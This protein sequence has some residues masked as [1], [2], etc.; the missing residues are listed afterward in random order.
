MG[1]VDLQMRVCRTVVV[2]LK[3]GFEN[4]HQ[5]L[6]QQNISKV[7]RGT[8]LTQGVTNASYISHCSGAIIQGLN[9][10]Q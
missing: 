9:C 8:I 3:T 6:K 5:K 7:H 1:T 10:A 2:H 4:I